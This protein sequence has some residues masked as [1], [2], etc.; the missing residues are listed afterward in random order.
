MADEPQPPSA[1]AT[2]SE[3]EDSRLSRESSLGLTALY[4]DAFHLTTWPGHVRISLGEYFDR[5]YYRAAVVMPLE[6]ARAL[7]KDLLQVIERESAREANE[8]REER[9]AETRG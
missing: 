8:Q 4:C 5:A 9:D 6:D 3:D 2:S 7:A 1:G